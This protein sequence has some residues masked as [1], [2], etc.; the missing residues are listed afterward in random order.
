VT[1]VSSPPKW[2]SSLSFQAGTLQAAWVGARV[3][4]G[5]RALAM[6]ADALGLG[7]VAAAFAVPAMITALPAGRM[8]D[9]F[10]GMK[11]IAAGIGVQIVGIGGAAFAEQF[12]WLLISA[13]LIGLGQIGC[14]V[15]LQS[16]VADKARHGSTDDAFGLLTAAVSVGQVVG[17]LVITA[18]ATAG[19]R[20]GAPE[21][22]TTLALG[23]AG[24]MIALALG[25]CWL[26]MRS[27]PHH[28]KNP[29]T[30]QEGHSTQSIVRT[31]GLWRALL[32]SGIVLTAM[33][34]LYAFLPAWAEQ[35]DV[36]VTAVGWLLALR[37]AVTVLSRIG[38][39]KLVARLGRQTLLLISLTVAAASLIVLPFVGAGGAIG[40]MIGLGIGLGL[41]QP[42]TM[43]WVIARVH[44]SAHG[45]ALGLRLTSN[46]VIQ[47]TVPVG[48]SAAAGSMGTDA[49][50]WASAILLTGA[51]AAV[52]SAGSTLDNDPGPPTPQPDDVPA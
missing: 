15:G 31:P 10:G 11:L 38:I 50:F 16:F 28:R 1:P 19:W 9:R 27:S 22:D 44:P 8:A 23:A 52:A 41:P 33:D 34:M 46:R 5:Y 39:G 25:P 48:V 37:A 20:P 30:G 40:V 14:A 26:L 35:N 29:A 51:I 18:V 36:S 7:L 4:I 24:L 49:I 42:L 45:A 21:P 43:A 12:G 3:M 2:R 13:F 17:P 6:D 47:I 32:V